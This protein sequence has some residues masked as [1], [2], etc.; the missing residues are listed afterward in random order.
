MT[1]HT[2]GES[3]HDC[4]LSRF[5]RNR[6]YHGKLMTAR[7][8]FADQRYHVDRLD[9][10]AQFV[11]GEGIV[12]GLE[13]T[14]SELDTGSLSVTIQKGLALDCCGRPIMV[15]DTETKTVDRDD[16]TDRKIHLYIEYAECNTESVPLQGAES[17]CRDQCEF[18]RTRETFEVVVGANPYDADTT[19]GEIPYKNV[20][21]FDLTADPD[22]LVTLAERFH[23]TDGTRRTCASG[24]RRV[25]LGTFDQQEGGN[26][27]ET[28]TWERDSTIVRGHVYTNDL[29]YAILTRHIVDDNPH[30]VEG[31]NL[32]TDGSIT[33]TRNQNPPTITLG[34]ANTDEEVDLRD[35]DR[36][37]VDKTLKY[38]QEVFRDVA[39]KFDSHIADALQWVAGVALD[40][41]VEAFESEEEEGILEDPA[42]LVGFLRDRPVTI[43]T[44]GSSEEL[45]VI[46][47][48]EELVGDLER[49]VEA[50]GRENYKRAVATL[51]ELVGGNSA[52]RAVIVALDFVCEI[53]SWLKWNLRCI[54][55]DT[56]VAV[57][58]APED[59]TEVVVGDEEVPVPV[60]FRIAQETDEFDGSVYDTRGDATNDDVTFTI[61]TGGND[62]TNK[63][64]T[65]R[66]VTG[67]RTVDNELASSE[68]T[69]TFT[70][71]TAPA[72]VRVTL[73]DT[74]V[75]TLNR[76]VLDAYSEGEPVDRD[77][78]VFAARPDRPFTLEVRNQRRTENKSEITEVRIRNVEP[79]GKLNDEADPL[80]L[81]VCYQT[82]PE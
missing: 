70:P 65:V 73:L 59:A 63:G 71:D 21:N 27:D 72:Y 44:D 19:E 33:I 49:L 74:T 11:A 28:V 81:E 61:M 52:L 20:P 46:E 60:E 75:D 26:G 24:Q 15:E 12:W 56:L 1:T 40:E 57:A 48:M 23:G 35:V 55:G 10:F 54:E 78:N 5:E 8:M 37:L 25:F 43:D 64:R 7:D 53:A 14:V 18:N 2:N 45:T 67:I 80:V 69:V 42:Q 51:K 32:D 16:I 4:T 41:G 58:D 36:Y 79:I 76:Y 6:Y 17:A 50:D 29:L 66:D 77:V 38:M 62:L 30:G 31:I 3:P 9:T 82:V 34:V 39:E 47:L 13:T 22:S 68:L